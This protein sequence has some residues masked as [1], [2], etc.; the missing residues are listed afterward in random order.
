MVSRLNP[1]TRHLWEQI[2]GI[3]RELEIDRGRPRRMVE[4]MA[5]YVAGL[6]LLEKGQTAVRIAT[7]LPARAHDALNRL[8]RVLPWSPQRLVLGLV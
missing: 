8:L 4:L 5:L 3:M 6:I 7:I 1:S 2:K